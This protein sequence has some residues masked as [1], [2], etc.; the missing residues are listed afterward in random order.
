MGKKV[1]F[2]SFFNGVYERGVETLVLQLGERLAKTCDFTVYQSGAKSSNLFKTK[3]YET[4]W[5]SVLQEPSSLKKRLF[6]D[7]TSLSVKEFM[8]K[9]LP[10][11]KREKYDIVVPCNNGWETILCKLNNVGKIV[12]IGQAGI[13]W[14]DRV[15]MWSFPDTFIG[16]TDYQCDWV[17]KNNPFVR[18]EKIP[19]GV[20]LNNFGEKGKKYK[21]DLPKPIILMVAALVPLKRQELAIRAVAKMKNGSLVLVGKGDDEVRLTRMGNELLPGRFKILSLTFD[22]IPEIYRSADL[23]TFPTSSWESFGLVLLEAMASNLPIVAT[24]D[25][26]R[27]EIVGDAGLFVDPVDT[28]KYAKTLEKV[29]EIKWGSKPREQAEKYSWDDIAKKY[30]KLFDEL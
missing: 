4:P 20:D 16:Y 5:N 15:N 3:I 6:L 2:L 12:T 1:A 14:D 9:I 17:H 10:D 8:Q 29:L 30:Q 11:L 7:P 22:K 27:R 19:N 13:G 21:I 25:P 28:Q 24:D 23:F 26:I 18:I